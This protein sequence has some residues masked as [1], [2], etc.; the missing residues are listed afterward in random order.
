MHILKRK[1]KYWG[2]KA[3]IAAA[4]SPIDAG[5][6]QRVS[7]QLDAFEKRHIR[8]Y[9]FRDEAG[10]ELHDS[11]RCQHSDRCSECRKQ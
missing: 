5:K 7:V 1:P 10:Q 11:G 3:V 6:D 8:R 4:N 2:C 9:V